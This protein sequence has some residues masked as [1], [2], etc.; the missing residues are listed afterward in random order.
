MSRTG[1]VLG[2]LLTK[3]GP[4]QYCSTVSMKRVTHAITFAIV[5]LLLPGLA[6]ATPVAGA[7]G[8]CGD[9]DGCH[10]QQP[11]QPAPETRSCCDAESE[12]PPEPSFGSSNCEC[13]REAP[14]ALTAESQTTVETAVATTL[15]QERISP[16][17]PIG[18]AFSYSTRLAAPPP[19]PPAYL[20]D[21]AF[22]T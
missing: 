3:Y 12:T 10:L 9:G 16:T 8:R 17:S 21:C 7:C 14:P 13:G 19:A 15:T 1:Q 18:A 4:V 6:L 5:A 22:L 20:I 2:L 11:N